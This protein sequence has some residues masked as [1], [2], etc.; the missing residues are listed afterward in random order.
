MSSVPNK[1]KCPHP[2]CEKLKVRC[3][4][5]CFKHWKQLPANIQKKILVGH[6]TDRGLWIEG[7]VAAKRYW[8]LQIQNLASFKEQVRRERN[9]ATEYKHAAKA[10]DLEAEDRANASAR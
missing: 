2:Q 5:A 4:Y 3:R 8:I 6:K 9:G 7:D 10:Q 1:N